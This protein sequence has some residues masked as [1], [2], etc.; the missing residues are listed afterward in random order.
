MESILNVDPVQLNSICRRHQIRQLSIFGSALRTD[1][2]PESDVD[3]L[4][5]FEADARIGFMALGAIEQEFEALFQRKVDLV[6]K[7][8]LRPLLE[9]EILRTSKLLYEAA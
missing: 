2:G 1:F 4:V 8:S 7:R 9:D 6:I 3:L 5:E